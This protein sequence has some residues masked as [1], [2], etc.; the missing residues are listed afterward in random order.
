MPA[1]QQ[2][3]RVRLLFA[4]AL[5]VGL[6]GVALIVLLASDGNAVE[7]AD[8][9]CLREWNSDQDA[10]G[11]GV[12]LYGGHGYDRVQVTRLAPDGGPLGSNERGFC[13][14]VFAAGA[15]DPELDAAAQF[16]DGRSWAPVSA[17]ELGTPERLGA[18]QREAL[19]G[20]N[21]ALQADGRLVPL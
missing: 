6:V 12:H 9:R 3:D 4:G 13:V 18:L 20:A 16:F 15:L 11:F 7:A 21:A 8:A 17:L 5:A 2:R 1:P 10:V 14:V 19:A